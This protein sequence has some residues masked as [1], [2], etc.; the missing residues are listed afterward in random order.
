MKRACII[1]SIGDL[2][3]KIDFEVVILIYSFAR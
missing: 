3:K 1:L 2:L